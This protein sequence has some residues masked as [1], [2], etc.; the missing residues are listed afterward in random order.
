MIYAC[1]DNPKILVEEKVAIVLLSYNSRDYLE[2]FL[3]YVLKTGYSGYKLIIVDNAS[4]DDTLNFLQERY[5][6]TDVLHIEK[7]RGF[8]NGFVES[9]PCIAAEY[10]ALLTSDVEV[11]PDW[12]DPLVEAMEEDPALAACQPKIK[13]Y[14]DRSSFEYAGAC[15]GFIDAFGYPFCRGRIFDN[16]EKDKGQ[17]DAPADVFWASGAVF[18]L[19][20]DAYYKAGG[21]DNDFFAHMEEID[22]C[23]RMQSAGYKIKAIPQSEVYH[24]GGSV[25]LYGSTE[26]IYHNYR[27]NLIMLT[28][29]LPA[30]RL[31]RMLP[32]RI[33]LDLISGVELLL[34]GNPKACAA[35]MKAHLHYWRSWKKHRRKYRHTVRKIPFR[36]LKGIYHK[37]IVLQFFIK[38]RKKYSELPG[39]KT[40]GKR[41]KTV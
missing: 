5:P 18:L 29:N 40:A 17:Y 38:G 2:R 36:E 39:I 16:V 34:T 35:M 24:V 7:N 9:L 12:L 4:T 32:W 19:R 3:P 15:G 28:K 14:N 37:S 21:F 23:W 41:S 26:K 27:N 6:Q 1:R 25:I 11:P 13:A 10:Y 33:L 8:T 30:G 20:S 31:L 22:L